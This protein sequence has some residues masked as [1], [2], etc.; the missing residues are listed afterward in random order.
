MS[1]IATAEERLQTGW[2]V[3]QQQWRT[4]CDLWNDPV[5][6]HFEREFWQEWEQIVPATLDAMQHLAEVISAAQ[7]GVR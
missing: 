6:S 3:L 5:R 4:T 2:R 7:H 1:A